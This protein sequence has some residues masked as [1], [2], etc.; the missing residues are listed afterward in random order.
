MGL[1]FTL[2]DS[3]GQAAIKCVVWNSQKDKLLELPQQGSQILVNGNV[4]LYPKRGEYQ[5][6]VFQVLAVGD[7]LQSLRYQQLRSRLEAEG[8]FDTAIKR[9]LPT[10]PQTIA[11]VTS[12]TAAAWGDIQR[13][14]AQR[15]PGIHVL[16]SP[17]TVQGKE[18]PNSIV[19]A[20]ERVK[21]DGRAELLILAR[22]GGAV[23]DLFCFND[24]RVVRAISQSSIPVIT[25]IG[26]QRDET[27]A[28]L[29]ADVNAHTP[30]A[31]A[32]IAVPSITV[33]V[34]EHQQRKARLIANLQRRL[35]Q[36][37]ESLAQVKKRLKNLPVYSASVRAATVKVHLLQQKLQALDPKAV[38]KRGF[39]LVRK[40]NGEVVTNSVMLD[41]EQEL[42]V[43]LPQ[44]AIKV[45]VTEI[46]SE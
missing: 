28:D 38:L 15:N 26:H 17:A 11:I 39:A 30:T 5:L 45:K 21:S 9:S 2:S 4:R 8:L 22:G 20:I 27:L 37:A 16:F 46:L 43:Q 24:E 33:L 14:L 25:G 7:G 1:F 31:A 42:V 35:R 40:T 29:V 12:S 44:G 6:T 34:T 36:E 13:T 32:E 10:Y 23:E 18:A 3:Q 19:S 41:T